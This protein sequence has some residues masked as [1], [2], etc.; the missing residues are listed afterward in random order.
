MNADALA[1][2]HRWLP[3]RAEER[4]AGRSAFALTAALVLSVGAL[5]ATWQSVIWPALLAPVWLLVTFLLPRCTPQAA[6]AVAAVAYGYALTM[7][8]V[9]LFCLRGQ[10]LSSGQAGHRA[11]GEHPVLWNAGL[12]W[13]GVEGTDHGLGCDRIPFTMGVDALLVDLAFW[14]LLVVAVTR[15][16]Q[17]KRLAALCATACWAAAVCGFL[18]ACRLVPLFD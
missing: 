10:A 17:P 3:F 5:L 1:Q 11:F 14:V 4:A 8:S 15:R 18:G 16:L 12:P 7:L 13:P 6:R 2:N 9:F